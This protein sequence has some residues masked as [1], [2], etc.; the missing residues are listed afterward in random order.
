MVKIRLSRG[1]AK[2]RPFYHIVV[3]DERYARDGRSIERLGFFN[4]IAA[5]KEVPLELNVTRA[6]EWIAKG[7][8]PTEKVRALLKQAAKQVAAAAA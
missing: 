6:N 8:Q 1:G 3:A 7:A 4:P 5:G 2:G